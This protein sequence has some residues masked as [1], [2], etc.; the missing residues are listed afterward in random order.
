MNNDEFARHNGDGL[1]ISVFGDESSSSAIAS[2]GLVA[3]TEADLPKVS[4]LVQAAK[5][6]LKATSDEP[7]HCKVLFH[8]DPIRNTLVPI[9]VHTTPESCW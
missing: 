2:Y 8:G 9:A 1:R 4:S 5:T 3:F 6:T 7:L